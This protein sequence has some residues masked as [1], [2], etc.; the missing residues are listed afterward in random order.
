M[1]GSNDG[2]RSATPSR[3]ADALACAHAAGIV[4]RDLKPANVVVTETGT[5]KVLDFGLAKL[6]A[7]MDLPTQTSIGMIMGTVAYMSPEQTTGGQVNAASDIFSFGSLLYELTTGR[8]AF[9]RDSTLATRA[10]SER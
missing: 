6:T 8:H 1:T 10:D 2:K 3:V 5:A 4:H 7:G 9:Q